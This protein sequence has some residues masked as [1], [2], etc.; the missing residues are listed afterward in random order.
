MLLMGILWRIIVFLEVPGMVGIIVGW[1]V[2]EII[3]DRR[4]SLQIWV[5]GTALQGIGTVISPV[6][7]ATRVALVLEKA[8]HVGLATAMMYIKMI[9][10][11]H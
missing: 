9:G 11:A 5:A 2:M 8:E 6:I 4:I 7:V 10:Y 3:M 1:G